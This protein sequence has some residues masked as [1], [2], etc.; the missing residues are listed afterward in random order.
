MSYNQGVVLGL[1]FTLV[2][3]QLR[4]IGVKAQT[5]DQVLFVL[6]SVIIYVI[7]TYVVI[8]MARSRTH[9]ALI[10]VA[11]CPPGHNL[12]RSNKNVP[13]GREVPKNPRRAVHLS[14]SETRFGGVG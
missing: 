2:G 1:N 14:G 10:Y 13:C 11:C 9:D 6:V 12:E 7:I 8:W 5:P 4:S 3:F